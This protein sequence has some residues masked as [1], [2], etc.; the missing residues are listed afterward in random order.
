MRN[1][2]AA[3]DSTTAADLFET[4]LV[5]T[6]LPKADLIAAGSPPEIELIPARRMPQ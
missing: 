6:D 5:A 2:W 3:T 4:D 1:Y